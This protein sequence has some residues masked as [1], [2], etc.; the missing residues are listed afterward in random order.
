MRAMQERYA[1][2][3]FSRLPRMWSTS[4]PTDGPMVAAQLMIRDGGQAPYSR[5]LFGRC[6]GTVLAEPL[7]VQSRTWLA[8]RLPRTRISTIDTVTRRSVI[9]PTRLCGTLYSRPSYEM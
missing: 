2:S 6:S 3:G 5:W 8:T 7:G 9:S 1:D 4:A